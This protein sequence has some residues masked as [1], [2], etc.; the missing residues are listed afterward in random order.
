MDTEPHPPLPPKRDPLETPT[1]RDSGSLLLDGLFRS[2]FSVVERFLGM[3]AEIFQVAQH[4]LSQ[5]AE[6]AKP[7]AGDSAA[8]CNL[9]AQLETLTELASLTDR[10]PFNRVCW[11]PHNIAW[12]EISMDEIKKVKN[13]FGT[14]VN[15]VLLAVL[16]SAI[17]RYS[18]AHGVNLEGRQMRVAVP[19]NVRGD[20]SPEH[21]GNRITFLPINLPLDISDETRLL[22]AIHS[23]IEIY[24]TAKVA[25]MVGLLGN[26]IGV[27]P[28]TFQA[29][30]A[31]ILSQLPL[32]LINTIITNV[33]GPQKP[34]YVAG[35][36][37]TRWYPVVPIGGEMSMNIAMLSYNGSVYIGFHGTV[38]AMPD[39]E[40]L[41]RL[42]QKSFAALR[43]AG[44]Q[45]PEQKKAGGT[46]NAAEKARGR[47]QRPATLSSKPPAKRKAAVA[48]SAAKPK[49]KP[50]TRTSAA[51][52]TTPGPGPTPTAATKPTVIPVPTVE[53]AKEEEP[54][55]TAGVA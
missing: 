45:A 43:K 11:G 21:L 14:T 51:D 13:V 40:V 52:K 49:R 1:P 55:W 25:G 35:H 32:N 44:E 33:P 42:V 18:K 24:K 28:T 27:L 46:T 7:A 50:G 38:E 26:V 10:L 34:L 47:I 4:L 53:P 22:Q 15:N 19:V 36:K 41:E 6:G 2:Y 54:V 9:P 30:A 39:I 16:T 20:D 31:P 29:M 5:R 17:R 37:M 48:K 23:K 3:Q 8:G 12:T